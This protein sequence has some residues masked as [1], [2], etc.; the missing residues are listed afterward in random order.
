MSCDV[1]G[2]GTEGLT[3]LAE[4]VLRIVSGVPR[5][6]VR[7]YG[8]RRELA[9]LTNERAR[10]CAAREVSMQLSSMRVVL[11]AILVV[12]LGSRPAAAQFPTTQISGPGAPPFYM[13]KTGST[14]ENVASVTYNIYK[15]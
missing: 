8:I 10:S 3:G 12:G 13:A 2:S 14:F 7:T 5:R 11:G 15:R 9:T 4:G 1:S 6:A